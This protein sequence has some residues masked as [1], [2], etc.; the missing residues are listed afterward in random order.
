MTFRLTKI[1]LLFCLSLLV[2]FQCFGGD[3]DENTREKS[4]ALTGF[5]TVGLARSSSDTAEYVRDLSQPRGLTTNWSGKIDSVLG[6]QANLSIGKNTE[7][8]MQVLSRYRYDGSFRPEVSWAFVRHDVSPELQV[9]A[10]RLGTEFYMLADSRLVGY[11][12]LTVR[13]SPDFFVPLIFTNFD[14]FD[15]TANTALLGGLVRGKV[16]FGYSPET[17]PFADPITWNVKGS[18]VMGGHIDYFSGPWQFRVGSTFVRFSS[19][20]L[21]LNKL[22]APIFAPLP[23]PDI[24]TLVPELSTINKTARFDSLGAV[25]DRGPAQVQAMIGRIDHQA[26]SYESS[27]AAFI[28]G[29]YRMG[30][31]TPYIGYSKVKSS[32]QTITTPIPPGLA[33]I[34]S[35]I[36]SVPHMDQHTVT[37]GTRWDF[38]R[39]LALKAQ[40]DAI[41]GAPESKFPFRGPAVQWNGRMQV[42]SVALDFAF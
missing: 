18:R 31:W 6:V 11:S 21:P 7:A 24:T 36:L 27:W 40:L 28:L 34:V 20:E 14:G 2:S 41:R 5:G 17:S 37:V 26:K 42:L 4:F 12:N 32:L 29:A 8:V 19:A 1:A 3:G 16:F 38:Y 39:N 33:P 15:A 23:A 9:R 13:P 10:G 35:G 25:F 30:E 22:I